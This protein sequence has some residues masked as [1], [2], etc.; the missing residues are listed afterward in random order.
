MINAGF[1]G[2]SQPQRSNHLVSKTSESES[3]FYKDLVPQFPHFGLVVVTTTM[4]IPEQPRTTSLKNLV[5][6]EKRSIP[7]SMPDGAHGLL[8]VTLPPNLPHLLSLRS[9]DFPRCFGKV[10]S[11]K[12]SAAPWEM[13]PP[14]LSCVVRPAYSACL[15]TCLTQN[16]PKFSLKPPSSSFLSLPLVDQRCTGLFF[17][18]F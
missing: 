16:K 2:L 4:A 3:A 7:K 17:F 10:F 6:L 15:W 11:Q 5:R 8:K 18:Y 12:F 9:Q 13:C 14:A 1:W